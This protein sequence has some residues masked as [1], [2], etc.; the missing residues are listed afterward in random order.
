MFVLAGAIG[1]GVYGGWL[2]KKRGGKRADIAQ[3]AA[4][5]AI[6]FALVGMFATLF[7]HRAMI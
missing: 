1:G 6:L 5:F 2:A 4:G 3:Y 7:F